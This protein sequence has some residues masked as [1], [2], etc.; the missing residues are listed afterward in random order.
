MCLSVPG[1][2]VDIVHEE[3]LLFGKVDFGGLQKRV[4]LDYVREV[5]VG[6]YV[7]VHVGFALCRLDEAE[8]E[9]IWALIEE[10][11]LMGDEGDDAGSERS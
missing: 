8:A 7:L 11:G 1:R 9:R 3:D 5:Q 10:D 6:E 2:V 4:C